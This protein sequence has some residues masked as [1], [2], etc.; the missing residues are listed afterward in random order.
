M[1]IFGALERI[2]I[3][4]KNNVRFAYVTYKS[5]RSTLLALTQLHLTMSDMFVYVQLAEAHKQ[6]D[7]SLDETESPFQSLIQDCLI[8]IFQYCDIHAQATLTNTCRKFS[9]IIKESIWKKTKQIRFTGP[10]IQNDLKTADSILKGIKSINVHFELFRPLFQ[11]CGYE[12]IIDLDSNKKVIQVDPH[13]LPEC[14]ISNIKFDKFTD[15]IIDYR[16][17]YTVKECLIRREFFPCIEIISII[18]P[19]NR[20]PMP[21]VLLHELE[22]VSTIKFINWSYF[23]SDFADADSL[24]SAYMGLFNNDY[25]F[26]NCTFDGPSLEKFLDKIY[27]NSSEKIFIKINNGQFIPEPIYDRY[28]NNTNTSKEDFIRLYKV[29]E[30]KLHLLFS[31]F[32]YYMFNCSYLFSENR[33]N[34]V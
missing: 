26:E 5:D 15:L 19:S 21:K 10:N 27:K 23:I 8:K 20:Q 12:I 25:T 24:Y 18:G 7:N 4:S 11:K 29:Q 34:Q 13:L 14:Y 33:R 22:C 31:S 1:N 2:Q 17:R 32:G 3:F 30:K 6:P 16:D 28:R 9:E